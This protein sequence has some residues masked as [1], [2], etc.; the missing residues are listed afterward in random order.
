M[1]HVSE[2]KKD[3]V[4]KISEK[5]NNTKV[6]GV[7]DLDNLPAPQ[8]Q[9]MRKNLKNSVEIF[10][11]KKRL[12][13]IAFEDAKAKKPGIEALEGYLSGMN[14]LIFTNDN[15]FKLANTLRKG[16]T[17]APAKPGQ[18][19]P[20]DIT[21]KAGATPFAPGPIIGELGSFGIKTGVE[22]GKVAVKEDKVVAKEGDVISAKL[23]GLLTRL[24]ITPMEIGL[25]ILGAYEEGIV[26][27]KKLLSV[28]PQVYID[29]LLLQA[30]EAHALA[31]EIGYATKDTV[32]N[33]L[34]NA[35]R[36][37]VSISLSAGIFVPELIEMLL[38]KASASAQVLSAKV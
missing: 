15:P 6:V 27:D 33:L 31:V 22:G 35:Q 21:V 18:T 28:D 30:K 29:N 4:A 23:A 5:I 17:S 36:N 3:I 9:Q 1:A 25:T 7:V 32:E 2:K 10:A 20:L 12:I 14:A 26:F 13:K 38:A 19:A 24:G 11:A 16:R 34:S 8:L 37:A